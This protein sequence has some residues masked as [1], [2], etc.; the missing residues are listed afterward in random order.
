[1]QTKLLQK[2]LIKGTQEFELG[3]ES[4]DIRIK[5]PFMKEEKL[6]VML[7]VLNAEPVI[8]QSR[9]EF[10]SR[11]NSEPLVSLYLGKPS[12]QEFNAFV[13]LLKQKIQQ[14]Y[15]AFAGLSP[16]ANPSL[17]G[18]VYDEPPNFDEVAQPADSARK[19]I[20]IEALD[21]SIAMLTEYVGGDEIAGLVDALKVLAAEPENRANL[22][23][24]A[25]E[26]DRLG[27]GQGAVLTYAPYIGVLL[28]DGAGSNP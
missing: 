21:E 14:E 11:V 12:T 15:K 1:M 8:S 3:D 6:T 26:F 19:P 27:P 25:K 22:S 24:L 28:S 18:N 2:H 13:N 16:D 7:A 23:L 9:L 17:Q 5:A 4:I 10:T 20:R